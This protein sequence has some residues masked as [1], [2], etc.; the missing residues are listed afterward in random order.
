MLPFFCKIMKFNEIKF[1][2]IYHI[3]ERMEDAKRY[4]DS[5]EIE[6]DFIKGFNAKRLFGGNT[7]L[8]HRVGTVG[9]YLSFLSAFNHARRMNY[10]YACILEDDA[11]FARD[12]FKEEIDNAASQLPVDWDSLYLGIYPFNGN[13]KLDPVDGTVQESFL[14]VTTERKGKLFYA[15]MYSHFGHH[16]HHATVYSQEGLRKVLAYTE[17]KLINESFDLRVG[18][19][20]KNREYFKSFIV[21]PV[22]ADAI[23]SEEIAEGLYRSSTAF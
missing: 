14:E 19:L 22:I 6:V 8:L 15:D 17:N 10:S 5:L 9:C 20:T 16:G 23:S 7:N 3:E 21:L 18:E 13:E 12:S 1:V 4:F 11:R 2:S